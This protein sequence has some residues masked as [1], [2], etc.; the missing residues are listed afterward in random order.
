MENQLIKFYF[1]KE[2]SYDEILCLLFKKHNI[3][4]SLS[5]LKRRLSLLGL[6]RK[7]IQ[8]SPIEEIIAAVYEE[9]CG[10]GYN[11]GY[12]AMCQKLRRVYGV[13]VKR[14]T[15]YEILKRLDSEGVL[16]RFGNKLRRRQ[17]LN[18]GPN[19]L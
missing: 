13:K 19:R 8:E 1:A 10:C 14:D 6:K 18:P 11:L 12:R 7:N 16:N 15:V 5:T 17:Y 4:L 3:K 9:L 2:C